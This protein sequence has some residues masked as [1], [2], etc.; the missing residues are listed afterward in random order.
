MITHK[1]KTYNIKCVYMN[2]SKYTHSRSNHLLRSA[3]RY[4]LAILLYC[5]TRIY[6]NLNT[7]FRSELTDA[8]TQRRRQLTMRTNRG[9]LVHCHS[10]ACGGIFQIASARLLLFVVGSGILVR[11]QDRILLQE[12]CT[13][14][15]CKARAYVA[16]QSMHELKEKI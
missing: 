5:F 2:K 3:Q 10:M 4:A 7:F 13:H 8:R 1:L 14:T 15:L 11:P 9:S 6:I 12:L 16:P